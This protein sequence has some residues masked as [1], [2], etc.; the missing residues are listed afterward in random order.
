M[1][2]WIAEAEERQREIRA[3]RRKLTPKRID[4]QYGNGYSEPREYWVVCACGEHVWNEEDY[5]YDKVEPE[6]AWDEHV[7]WHE[8]D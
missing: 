6:E 2:T 5:A 7:K 3:E 4:R 8:G 1:T